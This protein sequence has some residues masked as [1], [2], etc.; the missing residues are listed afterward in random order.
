MSGDDTLDGWTFEQSGP[1]WIGRRADGRRTA[2]K[3]NLAAAQADARAGR[4][5]C[6][7]YP[8]CPHRDADACTR[9]IAVQRYKRAA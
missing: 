4:V 7:L 2:L 1:D 6:R 5:V 9:A 3:G 8:D